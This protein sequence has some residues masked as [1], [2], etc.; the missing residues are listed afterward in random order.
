MPAC[1]SH[2]PRRA[3]TLLELLVVM[4]IIAVL[5]ALLLPAL[6]GGYVKARQTWCAS[7]LREVGL[8]FHSFAHEHDSVFPHQ[9]AV[10]RG[11]SRELNAL[12]PVTA[13][14]WLVHQIGRAHV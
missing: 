5:A 4:A 10:A 8:V 1:P 13:R 3:F 14:G 12:L 7:N 11:G 2:G 6:Q 9:V